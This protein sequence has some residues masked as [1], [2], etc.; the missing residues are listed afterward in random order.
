VSGSSQ[1]LPHQRALIQSDE[2]E[3]ELDKLRE[4]VSSKR[5]I[6]VV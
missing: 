1:S 4:N 5:E 3:E 6:P 2:E